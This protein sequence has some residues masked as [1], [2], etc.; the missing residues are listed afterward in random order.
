MDRRSFLLT[1]LAGA[2]AAPRAAGAQQVGKVYRLGVVWAISAPATAPY[3]AELEAGLR[4][5]GW[6]P[7]QSIVVEHRFPESPA[8]FPKL[9]A[10]VVA[11]R[12]DAIAAMTNAVVAATARATTE[13]PIVG[14][15]MSD[16][17]SAGFAVS[18]PRPGKNITGMTLD[19]SP[20]AYAKQLELL[21]QIVPNARRVQVL[22]NPDFYR[23]FNQQVYTTTVE[24]AAQS[25]RLEIY[26][27]DVRSVDEIERAIVAGGQKRSAIYAMLDLLTFVH[28]PLIAKLAA[29]QRLPTIFGF[30]EAVE[31]GALA[32]YG[33]DLV[34]MPR[35]AAR[36]IDRLFRGARAT[37]LPIEQPTKFELVI[38]L[39]TAKTLGLTI[40]PSLLAR[41]D[42]I[43]E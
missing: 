26:F 2:L 27:S 6:V 35:Y 37:D 13:I 23:T 5:L 32:S 19:A 43:I 1:S 11:A 38:N 4:E 20:G 28:G 40:P 12:V 16:P 8:D 15:Y 3:R 14:V 25:L 21:K 22:R 33:P 41:A 7:G 18:L 39:K 24:T 29:R 31:A 10:S 36:F 34:V 17:I 9:A 30:R 42:Q